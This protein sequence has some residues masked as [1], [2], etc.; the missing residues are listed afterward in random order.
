MP[1]CIAYQSR[2]MTVHAVRGPKH[3][4]LACASVPCRCLPLLST[5]AGPEMAEALT[6]DVLKLLVRRHHPSRYVLASGPDSNACKQPWLSWCRW[7][8]Y[9]SLQTTWGAAWV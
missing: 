3:S 1:T 7:H 8:T 4:M 9:A 2:S 5:V 6:S